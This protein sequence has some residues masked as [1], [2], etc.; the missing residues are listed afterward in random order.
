M[1]QARLQL[2]LDA[3]TR[4]QQDLTTELETLQGRAERD[5]AAAQQQIADIL[6]VGG[7]C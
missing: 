4:A 1:D 3:A 7:G 5:R 6:K 2:E